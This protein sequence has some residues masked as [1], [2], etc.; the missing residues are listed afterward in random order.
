MNTK[1]TEQATTVFKSL[2]EEDDVIA[3]G[4]MRELFPSKVEFRHK[5][6]FSKNAHEI[7]V[8]FDWKRNDGWLLE[9]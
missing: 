9:D 8:L 4:M 7:K 2:T 1:K 6:A 5:N 3:F